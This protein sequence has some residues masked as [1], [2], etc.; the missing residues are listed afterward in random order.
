MLSVLVDKANEAPISGGSYEAT[1]PGH[2]TD[3]IDS[4]LDPQH[5]LCE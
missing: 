5:E 4:H 1:M 2:C 3:E